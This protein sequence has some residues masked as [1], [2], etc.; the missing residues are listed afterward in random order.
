MFLRRRSPCV[1]PRSDADALIDSRSHRERRYLLTGAI[2]RRPRRSNRSPND[3]LVSTD[4]T[5][6]CHPKMTPCSSNEPRHNTVTLPDKLPMLLREL[7]FPSPQRPKSLPLE[8]KRMR[9]QGVAPPTSPWCAQPL[10]AIAHPLL[11]WALFPSKAHHSSL[12]RVQRAPLAAREARFL[13]H[14]E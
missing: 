4:I 11:P 7:L 10:P 6:P 9:L 8:S 14:P 13:H 5:A 2:R 12:C 3:C 1:P